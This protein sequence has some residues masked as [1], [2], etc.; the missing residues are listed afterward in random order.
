MKSISYKAV[1]RE[2]C[3]ALSHRSKAKKSTHHIITTFKSG[4]LV[5]GV[6]SILDI[7]GPGETISIARHGAQKDI[8]SLRGDAAAIRKDFAA[9]MDRSLAD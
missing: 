6:V 8:R 5:G 9:V 7:L 4:S 1:R 3:K 2:A